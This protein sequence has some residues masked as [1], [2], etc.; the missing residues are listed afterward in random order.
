MLRAPTARAC[1]SPDNC[2]AI[3][4][5]KDLE[6]L[7][8]L[9]YRFRCAAPCGAFSCFSTAFCAAALRA[10]TLYAV[11]PDAVARVRAAAC[12]AFVFRASNADG[13]FA[14]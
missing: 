4:L 3:K 8:A 11:A 1:G 13:S 9:R 2:E 6:L 10:T 12:G 7:G 14:Q 5:L